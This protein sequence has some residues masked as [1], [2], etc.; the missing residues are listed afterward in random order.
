MTAQEYYSKYYTL[1]T[2]GDS[3]KTVSAA[4]MLLK[5]LTYEMTENAKTRRFTNTNNAEFLLMCEE[6]A[7]WNKVVAM[8]EKKYGSGKS[9]LKK[10]GFKSW[11]EKSRPVTKHGST[12]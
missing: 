7:K 2:S 4:K 11:Y 1:L 8:F 12:N 10:N 3:D 5:D 9:P 6:N